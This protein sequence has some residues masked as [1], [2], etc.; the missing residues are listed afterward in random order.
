M[1]EAEAPRSSVYD[2]M[3]E[4]G[5]RACR[6]L[7]HAHQAAMADVL[8]D[9]G[10]CLAVFFLAETLGIFFLSRLFD[11]PDVSPLVQVR[12]WL[13]VP[14][15]ARKPLFGLQFEPSVDLSLIHI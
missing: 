3:T 6:A 13:D 10:S 11:S 14:R 12:H 2:S 9:M 5:H 15:G 4:G 7:L 1:V 8:K